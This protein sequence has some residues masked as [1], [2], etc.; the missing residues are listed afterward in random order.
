M[1]QRVEEIGRE[2]EKGMQ[3]ISRSKGMYIIFRNMWNI[4][5][6]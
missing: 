6:N 2:K 4:Y 5:K 1:R 3:A